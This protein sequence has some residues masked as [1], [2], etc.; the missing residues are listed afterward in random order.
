MEY[1]PGDDALAIRTRTGWILYPVCEPDTDP[2]ADALAVRTPGGWVAFPVRRPDPGD[3]AL[4]VR[5]G[6]GWIVSALP[7]PEEEEDPPCE[8]TDPLCD[9]CPCESDLKSTYVV[10]ISG[11][12]TIC[13]MDVFNGSWS[14][15]WQGNCLW[16]LWITPW[17]HVSLQKVPGG[18][19][20]VGWSVVTGGIAAAGGIFVGG[21]DCPPD[22]MTFDYF[23]CHGEEWGCEGMC[24][25]IA[26]ASVTVAG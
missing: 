11:F 17:D 9:A 5:T 19:W 4:A 25:A 12:P 1:E 24:A 14:V 21:E 15:Q 7:C 20:R 6:S 16:D 2:G 26:G 18:G 3:D 10:S 13:G 23:S 8:G 22:G